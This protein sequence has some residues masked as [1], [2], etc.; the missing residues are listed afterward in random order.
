MVPAS[1]PSLRPLISICIPTYNRGAFLPDLLRSIAKER[2]ALPDDLRALGLEVVIS[3]NCS[4]DDTPAQAA[5]FNDLFDLTYLRQTENIGPDRNF[6]AVVAAAHGQ[7][8]W[9]MGSDDILEQ[10]GLLRVMQALRQWNVAG[11]SVNYVRRSFD[12]AD[13]RSVRPAVRFRNDIVVTGRD[14][15]YRDFVGHWGYLSAHI[16][17][18]NLWQAVVESGEPLSFLNAYVHIFIMAKMIEQHPSWGY[19]HDICVGWRGRNDSFVT[20]DH[21]SRMMIDVRGYRDITHHL[22]GRNSRT[23]AAVTNT[24]AGTH[25]LVHYQIAKVFFTSGRTLRQAAGVLTKEYWRTPAYWS[26]LLP[27]IVMPAPALHLAWVGYQRMRLRFDP[28]F[29]IHPQ[30]RRKPKTHR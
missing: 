18:R 26:K 21:V 7:F 11:L 10:G 5:S 15:I 23:T 14:E 16:I 3:D 8:C 20:H 17:R 19:L 6:L 25:V 29:P 9:L 27:W 24:I 13:R 2:D 1:A 4:S 30:A 12:L 22:F 28:T